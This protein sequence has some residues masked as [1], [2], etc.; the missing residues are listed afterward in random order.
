MLISCMC[1][2]QSDKFDL[3]MES[4][5]HVSNMITNV[6]IDGVIDPCFWHSD[7]KILFGLKSLYCL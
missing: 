7:L 4:C 2:G 5:N 3:T 6:I 1:L